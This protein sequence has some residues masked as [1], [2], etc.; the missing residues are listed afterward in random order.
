M[1]PVRQDK[2]ELIAFSAI[3]NGYYEVIRQYIQIEGQRYEV[4]ALIPLKYNYTLSSD[5]LVDHFTA[6]NTKEIPSTLELSKRPTAFEIKSNL[7]ND[8][9]YLSGEENLSASHH[10]RTLF[11][12]YMIA[13]LFLMASIYFVSKLIML[14]K[15]PTLGA[16]F[17]IF[18]VF[19]F[20]FCHSSD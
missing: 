18:A 17:L 10:Q 14:K 15:N 20:R 9:V 13:T 19:V 2:S 1:G 8:R 12:L 5:Y 6:S 11:I 4:A 16:F 3:N 7:T